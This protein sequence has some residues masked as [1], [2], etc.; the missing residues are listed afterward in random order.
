MSN[1]RKVWTVTLLAALVWAVVPV[2]EAQPP[3]RIGASLA[4]TDGSAAVGQN[5]R[6]GHAG[7]I[8]WRP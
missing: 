5:Q 6:R 3:I 4:Q 2:A 7:A 1:A 8:S